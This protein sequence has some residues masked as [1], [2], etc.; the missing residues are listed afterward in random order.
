MKKTRQFTVRGRCPFPLDMLRY[1]H[2]YPYQQR[3][4]GVI[5]KSQ[6]D[7]HRSTWYVITLETNGSAPTESR[8]SELGWW[9]DPL[10]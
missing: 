5:E 6:R 2:C 4:V 9:V 10:L 3:D 8:W 7:N 1:D